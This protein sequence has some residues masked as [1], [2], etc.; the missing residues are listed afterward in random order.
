MEAPPS[1]AS[2]LVSS[3]GD[4]HVWEGFWR[5]SNPCRAEQ[6]SVVI[7]E[8]NN[9]EKIIHIIIYLSADTILSRN[10]SMWKSAPPSR[11]NL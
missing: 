11:I 10:I 6:C 1:L 9:F 4:S 2:E 5:G 7:L 3:P 8:C